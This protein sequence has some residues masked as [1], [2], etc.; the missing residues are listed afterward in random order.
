[1]RYIKTEE[2]YKWDGITE[3]SGAIYALL[4]SIMLSME[5]K[6]S[7]RKEKRA[8]AREIKAHPIND[9][10]L[11]HDAGYIS[12][13]SN[14]TW[15]KII[16]KA[17]KT[18]IKVKNSAARK[19]SQFFKMQPGETLFAKVDP[20]YDRRETSGGYKNRIETYKASFERKEE[21]PENYEKRLYISPTEKKRKWSKAPPYRTKKL[22]GRW[23]KNPKY[24]R[25]ELITTETTEEPVILHKI[26]PLIEKP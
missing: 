12:S 2:E 9:A 6:M 26:V 14:K 17:G 18:R 15:T 13:D 3:H 4:C 22:Y 23:S 7:T 16:T 8:K 20:N 5:K 1:V 24:G 11:K 25:M 21:T 19:S 10:K